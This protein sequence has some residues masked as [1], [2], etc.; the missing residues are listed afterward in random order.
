MGMM[1]CVLACL[2]ILSGGMI[3]GAVLAK[4]AWHGCD[5]LAHGNFWIMEG[6]G[7]DELHAAPPRVAILS[8]SSGR[9][10]RLPRLS[11]RAASMTERELRS[12]T[13]ST[14]CRG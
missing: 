12:R 11:H 14:K 7:L 10:V 13:A 1:L 8:A 5:Q 2:G 3:V 4:I 6:A 9:A